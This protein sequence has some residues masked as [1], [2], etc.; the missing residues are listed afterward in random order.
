MK[1]FAMGIIKSRRDSVERGENLGPDLITRFVQRAKGSAK[2]DL[3]DQDMV[4]IVLNFVIAGRDTTASGLSWAL[5][6]LAQSPE[7]V[8]TMCVFFVV[9]FGEKKYG[10]A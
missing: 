10:G 3:S 5:F 7:H 6:E 1:D 9:V 4:D 2:V 8:D